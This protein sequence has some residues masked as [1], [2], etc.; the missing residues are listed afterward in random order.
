MQ[1]KLLAS[2]YLSKHIYFT[3]REDRCERPDGQIVDPYFVVELPPSACAMAVTEDN[4]VVL[5]RQYRHAI[6]ETI[7]EIPGGFIDAGEDHQKAIARELLEETG[8]EFASYDYLGKITANPGMLD[9]YTYLYLARG[10][11]K[12]AEQKLDHNEDIDLV[13]MPLEDFRKMLLNNEIVQSLH[14]A[15]VYYAFQKIDAGA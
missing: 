10:G 3:A 14:M 5:V 13:T 9:N 4:E 11:K 8:Y 1:W 15:C 7:L 2:K 12:I 6:G